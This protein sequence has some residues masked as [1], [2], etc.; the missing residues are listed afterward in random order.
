MRA[1]IAIR[2]HTFREKTTEKNGWHNCEFLSG[3]DK[4]CDHKKN[5]MQGSCDQTYEGELRQKLVINSIE[6]HIEEPLRLQGFDISY[7]GSVKDCNLNATIPNLRNAIVSEDKESQNS[8]ISRAILKT[9]DVPDPPDVVVIVRAD[10]TFRKNIPTLQN[11]HD[12]LAIPW[13]RHDR[14]PDQIHIVGKNR[15]DEVINW[16]GTNPQQYKSMHGISKIKS[17]NVTEL[18]PGLTGIGNSAEC[19]DDDCDKRPFV[20]CNKY[21]PFNWKECDI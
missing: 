16:F 13:K 17:G 19:D 7:A 21:Q 18:W 1:V 20:D 15:V 2:G 12:I 14:E 6:T 3:K 10:Q 11:P 5:S 8:T 4:R 9:M